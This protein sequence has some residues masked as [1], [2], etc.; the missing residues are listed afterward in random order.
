MLSYRQIQDNTDFAQEIWK[1][2]QAFPDWFK[3]SNRVW[4]KT[5]SDFLEFWAQ[6]AEIWGLF[7]RDEL[8]AC[9]YIDFKSKT[10][11][12]VH[13]AVVGK[14]KPEELV[15]FF[16]S[17]KNFK[18]SQGVE[19]I[20]GWMNERNR[21]LIEIGERAGFCQT[22]LKMSFGHSGNRVFTWIQV[23]G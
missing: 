16:A 13:I 12:E 1:I 17:L 2:E 4:I 8:I 21:H 20:I 7:R 9:V 3:D 15:R 18:K 22:G 19:I 6:C 10:L 14:V 5:Y 23:R 11:V